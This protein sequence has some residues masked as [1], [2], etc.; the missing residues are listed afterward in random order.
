LDSGFNDSE[1]LPNEEWNEWFSAEL[2]KGG[3][4]PHYFTLAAH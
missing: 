3:A 1:A 4:Q 2:A